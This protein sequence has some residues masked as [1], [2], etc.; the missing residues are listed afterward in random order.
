MVKD[1]AG[2]P[3]LDQFRNRP[4]LER[5][6]ASIHIHIDGESGPAFSEVS[7]ASLRG[8]FSLLNHAGGSQLESIMQASFDNLESLKGWISEKHCC[9]FARQVAEWAPYQYRYVIPT[10]LVEQLMVDQEAQAVTTRHTS[11]AAMIKT[12]LSSPIP[13][14]NLSSSDL[15]SKLL[16]LLLR[17]A[18]ISPADPLLAS[19][20]DCIAALGC[21]VYYSDQIQ[22]LAVCDSRLS[23]H[24]PPYL[25][26]Y[27]GRNHQSFDCVGGADKL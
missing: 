13:M 8:M 3:Y 4:T 1:D 20:C 18:S 12:V 11:L 19:I 14:I 9:W 5:R 22:D 21:H 24:R 26:F 7:E 25:T 10:W 15:M 6:A 16:T 27:P 2:S 23:A 17:R